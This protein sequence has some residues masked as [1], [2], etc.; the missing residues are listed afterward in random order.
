MAVNSRIAN[1]IVYDALTDSVAMRAGAP[2]Q[3]FEYNTHMRRTLACVVFLCAALAHAAVTRVEIASRTPIP[4]SN[5]EKI[6]GAVYFALDPKLPANRRIADIGLAPRNAKG[7]VEFSS[8]LIVF[9]PKDGKG[10]GTA[11][12]EITNRGGLGSI[13]ALH[14]I[15]ANTGEY[16]DQFLFEQGYTLVLVGWEWDI[17]EGR[18]LLKLHAPAAHGVSGP[19]AAEILVDKKST[20]ESL[21]DRFMVAYPVA[22]R[23][24]AKMTV[25]DSPYGPRREIPA[26]EWRV[27][28]DGTR[29][30]YPAGFEPGK[31]YE[32]VYTAKDPPIAGLGLAAT[33]DY[34]SYL[35]EHGFEKP[36]E[37]KRAMTLGVSQSGRFLRSFLYDG[38]NADERGAKVFDAVWAHI[39]GAG[40]GGFNM[41]FAQ[42]SRMTG[43]WNGLDNPSDLPPFSPA[44]IAA[45]SG[46][47]AVPKLILTNG[48]HEYWGRAASLLHV[49]VDGKQD[50]AIPA[51][52]RIYYV[53]GTQ[54]TSATDTGAFK[55]L[56]QN[57]TNPMEWRWFLRATLT[58]INAWITK[59]T[60]PPPSVVPSIAKGDLVPA[61]RVNFPKIPGIHVPG[62]AY[63]PHELDFG[64]EFAEKGIASIEPPKIGAAYITLVPQ[65]NDDGNETSGIR[66]PELR[67]PLATY[68]G[69]NLRDP[70]AGGAQGLY[71]LQGS[72][73]P[74]PRTKADRE[75]SGD[76][77]PSIEERYKDEF[78]Y[79]RRI[80][81]MAKELARERFL[82]ERDIPLVVA[83][84]KGRWQ[85]LAA[86]GVAK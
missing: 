51:G 62:Q 65:V 47:D 20:S 6:T 2:P 55:G 12:L 29:A 40:R 86:A 50:A 52:V 27:S 34:I 57:Q 1:L 74:F 61:A 13:T 78:D 67:V 9:R 81:G 70:K 76:P 80:E 43:Q 66:L 46:P 15:G 8:D 64:P 21:G 83:R 37:I 14:S 75:R 48:S 84:A 18:N 25:R 31:F 79:L 49:T 42:P 38:F 82:L 22:D 44:K 45:A 33:R 53:A 10:N 4:N 19:V 26:S 17:P 24:T 73:I 41:R 30:E 71:P 77:R 85:T 56:A 59:G 36:G 58:N 7:L 72:M 68:T 60:E 28:A 11:L 23:A 69:W 32:V 63:S 54:H 5:Y 39:A 3:T 16:G 35:K